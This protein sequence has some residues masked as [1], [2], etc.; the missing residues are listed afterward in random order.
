[1]WTGSNIGIQWFMLLR[2]SIYS[3]MQRPLPLLDAET[4]AEL[5]GLDQLFHENER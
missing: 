5:A 2:V 4:G 1:M 3:I